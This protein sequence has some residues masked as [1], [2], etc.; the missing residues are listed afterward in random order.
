M[1]SSQDHI[2]AE[3]ER[4]KTGFKEEIETQKRELDRS[5]TDG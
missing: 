1:H 5:R 4:A 3:H 2:R